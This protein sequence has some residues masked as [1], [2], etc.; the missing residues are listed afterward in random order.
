MMVTMIIERNGD[1][2]CHGYDDG[3]DAGD[4]SCIGDYNDV[5]MVVVI[6]TIMVEVM[7][8]MMVAMMI[9]EMV[10]MMPVMVVVMATMMVVVMGKI[11]VLMLVMVV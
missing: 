6:A 2:I 4:G 8:M 11:L 9:K 3:V 5:V 1:G 10:T 7:A